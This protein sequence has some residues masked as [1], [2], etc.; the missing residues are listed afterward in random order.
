VFGSLRGLFVVCLGWNRMSVL[1]GAAVVV[2]VL[3]AVLQSSV[4]SQASQVAGCFRP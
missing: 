1:G 3:A 4:A 2:C